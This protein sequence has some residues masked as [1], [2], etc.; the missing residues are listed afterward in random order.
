MTH[1]LVGG[2]RPCSPSRPAPVSI[3][4]KNKWHPGVNID[5]GF[6]FMV[7]RAMVT[8]SARSRDRQ[9]LSCVCAAR[10]RTTAHARHVRRRVVRDAGDDDDLRLS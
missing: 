3:I 6:S 2:G 8:W 7:P 5:S 10:R 1:R 4:F 9:Q